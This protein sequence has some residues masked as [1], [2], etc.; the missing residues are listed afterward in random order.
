MQLFSCRKWNSNLNQV[1][2][3][4]KYVQ[5]LQ[6]YKYK[7]FFLDKLLTLIDY[8]QP[9]VHNC[10]FKMLCINWTEL[11]LVQIIFTLIGC[12]VDGTKPSFRLHWVFEK[13]QE[14][15]G[16]IDQKI[17]SSQIISCTNFFIMSLQKKITLLQGCKKFVLLD[18]TP[19][20]L[21]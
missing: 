9:L 17:Y 6:L 14:L 16:F 20:G 7:P 11:I 4:L 12:K 18:A 5:V 8:T 21:H 15:K 1:V 13:F 10:L 2:I 3:L 19:V